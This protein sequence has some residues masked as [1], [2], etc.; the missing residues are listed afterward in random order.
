MQQPLLPCMERKVRSICGGIC[1]EHM[2]IR[3]FLHMADMT[4]HSK[5]YI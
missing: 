5:R 1:Y 4:S 3:I 2:N